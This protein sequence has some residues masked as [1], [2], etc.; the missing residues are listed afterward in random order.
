MYELDVIDTIQ[1]IFDGLNLYKMNELIQSFILSLDDILEAKDILIYKT[2]LEGNRE[3]L[4]GK[5]SF[6]EIYFVEDRI[7]KQ[8][9]YNKDYVYELWKSYKVKNIITVQNNKNNIYKSE[10]DSIMGNQISLFG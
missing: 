6:S 3:E 1:T 4:K 2:T 10:Y 9:S 8:I 7:K 5:Y